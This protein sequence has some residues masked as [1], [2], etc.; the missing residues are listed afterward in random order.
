M[1]V[2]AWEDTL[3]L[4][5]YLLGPEDPLPHWER[6]GMSRIY[7]YPMQD[8]LTDE[9]RDVPYRA[10]HIGNDYLHCIAYSPDSRMLVTSGRFQP[11]L[12]WSISDKTL[13]RRLT[14][15]GDSFGAAAFSPDGTYLACATGCRSQAIGLFSI[16]TADP[17]RIFANH[18]VTLPL[19]RE[20]AHADGPEGSGSR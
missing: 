15:L 20:I 13:I 18:D 17:V 9:V 1:S 8:D 4:K 10:L 12:L 14:R 16:E 6:T 2:R 7:P 19:Q 11:A 3:V 5:T